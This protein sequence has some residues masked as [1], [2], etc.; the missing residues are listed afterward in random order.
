M[1]IDKEKQSALTLAAEM[2]K[3]VDF[4][5]PKSVIIELLTTRIPLL[6]SLLGSV[7]SA[8]I[9]VGKLLNATDTIH[10][11]TQGL[12]YTGI[13]LD[14]MN[15]L[16]I[17]VIYLASILLGQK[18]PFTLSNNAKWLYSGIT[19][20]LAIVA[21]T[22]PV[23]ALPI[24]MT[25]AALGLAI[26]LVTLGK[27][28]YETS[29]NKEN[30]KQLE[31]INQDLVVATKELESMQAYAR[32]LYTDLSSTAPSSRE[33]EGYISDIHHLHVQYL[34][35]ISD[36]QALQ[37]KKNYYEVKR[38]SINNL[39]ALD[40]CLAFALSTLGVLGV[41]FLFAIP[42]VG[43][44][45]MATTAT[46]GMFY[47]LG[48]AAAAIVPAVFQRLREKFS[49]KAEATEV[50]NHVTVSLSPAH[51]FHRLFDTH[52][53]PHSGTIPISEHDIKAFSQRLATAVNQ[54]NKV[55][56]LQIFIIIAGKISAY[57]PPL[58]ASD[59]QDFIDTQEQ[60]LHIIPLLKEA[61][62]GVLGNDKS[63]DLS[64]EER[65]QLSACAPLQQLLGKE[66]NLNDL[67]K[68]H[69]D[70]EESPRLDRDKEHDF[71]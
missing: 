67:I 23:A 26:S 46:I 24:A 60:G 61:M 33:Y 8:G 53:T 16:R 30:G 5:T 2:N 1:L 45:I 36:I 59:I 51:A 52:P 64:T 14:F 6:S 69:Q 27:F 3:K 44:S 71:T 40:K 11:T 50:P 68:H 63:L 19:I 55:D 4:K 28:L 49:K 31:S 39:A 20:T 9:A 41:G 12:K 34:E 35:K 62:K 15:F 37:D 7:D 42:L 56:I 66:I 43:F 70:G 17:P 58:S 57:T 18:V 38:K 21:L 10:T 13:A 25:S 22:V 47:L 65:M 48:R 54:Q 29:Q 32:R